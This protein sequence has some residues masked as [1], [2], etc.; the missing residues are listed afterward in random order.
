MA[1][2]GKVVVVTGGGAGLG[3]DISRRL[4]RDGWVVAI[5]GRRAARLTNVAGDG[6]HAYICDVADDEKVRQT[7]AEIARE[8]GAVSALINNAGV[9]RTG[10]F[11]EAKAADIQEQIAVNLVGVFSCTRHFA[12]ALKESRGAIVNI[13]SALAT[14]PIPNSA[15]YIATKGALEAFTRAMALELGPEV[16]VNAIA[17]GLVRSDIYIE[18]GM[19][20]A[21]YQ[22]M[23]DSFAEKYVL[24]RHGE[25]QDISDAVAFLVSDQSSWIT[26]TTMRVDS[27]FIDIG[28]RN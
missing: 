15:V 28:F 24:G 21:D 13:S 18:Q 3:L 22:A 19:P 6:I 23:L 11:L 4:R 27:G 10:P 14:R 7:A 16:R 5:L 17:P 25:P 1:K 8:L 20:P 12:P 26:G 9:I 2:A